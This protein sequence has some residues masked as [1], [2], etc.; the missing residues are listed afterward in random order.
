[1][2]LNQSLKGKEYQEIP[3]R[4]ERDRVTQFAQAVGEDDPR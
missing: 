4:V 2:P 3:F 1:M